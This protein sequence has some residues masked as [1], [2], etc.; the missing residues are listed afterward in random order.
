M[1]LFAVRSGGKGSVPNMS[2][3]VSFNISPSP[4]TYITQISGSPTSLWIRYSKQVSKISMDNR[5]ALCSYSI[6]LL[7]NIIKKMKILLHVCNSKFI[8]IVQKMIIAG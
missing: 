5:T 7:E 6:I 1:Y 2:S 8:K 4:K 3:K